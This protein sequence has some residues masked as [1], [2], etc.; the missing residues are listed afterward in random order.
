[1]FKPN[2]EKYLRLDN[3]TLQSTNRQFIVLLQTGMICCIIIP[4]ILA[5]ETAG[6]FLALYAGLM[7]IGEF[8]FIL[9]SL[10]A[11]KISIFNLYLYI[12]LLSGILRK[13]SLLALAFLAGICI[14]SQSLVGIII[15]V[16]AIISLL[17]EQTL[18]LGQIKRTW[19]IDTDAVLPHIES[20]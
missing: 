12:Q 7:L 14:R 10:F 5:K 4:I 1:M 16:I 13:A 20:T 18:I 9:S 8:I 6:A 3:R 2:L 19:I 15:G 11:I 17:S